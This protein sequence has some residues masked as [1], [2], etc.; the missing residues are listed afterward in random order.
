VNGEKERR[1]EPRARSTLVLGGV[2]VAK[3]ETLQVL[4]C[5]Q[6]WLGSKASGVGE[7]RKSG[8]VK[9]EYIVGAF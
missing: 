3:D 8:R 4:D 2:E 9:A 6:L 1:G 5:E 7:N